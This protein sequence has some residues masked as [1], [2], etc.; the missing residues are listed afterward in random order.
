MLDWLA[1]H[2]LQIVTMLGLAGLYLIRV[3]EWK[4]QREFSD[5]RQIDTT[6]I[7]ATASGV[8]AALELVKSELRHEITEAARKAQ[9][10]AIN[11]VEA[12]LA[13]VLSRCDRAGEQSSELT[14]KV[15]E[16]TGR[17]DR[18]PETLRQTFL[19]LERAQGFI[20]ESRNDRQ[21][22]WKAI[23]HLEPPWD[24][25]TERRRS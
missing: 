14:G 18:M 8:S 2:A 4:A 6:A 25:H 5:R 12:Q 11:A 10:T 23:E 21:A 19:S 17:I 3:G 9:H 15:Q 13:V 24:G 22:L 7:I 20:D 16:L 1:Q